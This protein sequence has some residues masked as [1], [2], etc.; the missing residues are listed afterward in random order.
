MLNK[1]PVIVFK[2]KENKHCI[3]NPCNEKINFTLLRLILSNYDVSVLIT[4][5]IFKNTYLIAPTVFLF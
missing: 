1:C 5:S 3:T 2:G 4:Q